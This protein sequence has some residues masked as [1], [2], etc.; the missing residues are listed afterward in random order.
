MIV[1][2]TSFS[3]QPDVYIESHGVTTLLDSCPEKGHF[4]V[5]CETTAVTGN[6]TIVVG[7]SIRSN[8]AYYDS[9]QPLVLQLELTTGTAR[10]AGGASLQIL[11]QGMGEDVSAVTATVGGRDCQVL[12]TR[13]F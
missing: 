9:S 6:V 1:D 13:T 10:T 4:E 3:A 7:G 11:A 8:T 5:V 12:F 2:G